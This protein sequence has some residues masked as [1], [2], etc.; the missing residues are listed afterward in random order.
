VC[1]SAYSKLSDS[2]STS[3]NGEA[4]FKIKIN[5]CFTEIVRLVAAEVAPPHRVLLLDTGATT[6]RLVD[7]NV[8]SALEV[9]VPNP[10]LEVFMA[11]REIESHRGT[12]FQGRVGAFL[13]AHRLEPDKLGFLSVWMD[14]CC[15]YRG[16]S[17]KDH[18]KPWHDIILLCLSQLF[19]KRAS[20]VLEVAKACCLQAVRF[21]FER[22]G[23]QV[24]KLEGFI[25]DATFKFNV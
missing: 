16:S 15:T 11:M 18:I 2:Y 12:V 1:Q 6:R 17:S 24:E 4:A 9:V 14:Y 13:S 21:F 3:T 8:S 23:K 22:S 20:P 5:E 25:R 7:A 19:Q 10:S